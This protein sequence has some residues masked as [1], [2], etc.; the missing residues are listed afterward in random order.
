MYLGLDREGTIE[1]LH[2]LLKQTAAD[3]NIAGTLVLACK[4]NAFTPGKVDR[5]L[6]Q[7]KK[8]VFGGIFPQILFGLIK[9]HYFILSQ[10]GCPLNNKQPHYFCFYI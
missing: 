8:P 10:F 6:K 3:K 2:N 4:A 1:G 5:F 7:C 9:R